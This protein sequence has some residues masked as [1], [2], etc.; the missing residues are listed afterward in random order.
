MGSKVNRIEISLGDIEK[1]N[2]VL[3]ELHTA[4]K[5]AVNQDYI[6]ER[7]VSIF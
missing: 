4:T 3:L 1:K 2:L 6:P 7:D 5:V